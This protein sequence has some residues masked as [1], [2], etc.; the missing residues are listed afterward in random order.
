LKVVAREQIP[1]NAGPTGPHTLSRRW[2]ISAYGAV[3]AV[4]CLG[5]VQVWNP[6]DGD[7]T[8]FLYA[9]RLLG[10][11][12]ALYKDVWDV[13]QPGIFLFYLA[14][15]RLF[16][17][18]QCGVHWMELGWMAVTGG[19]ALWWARK[20]GISPRLRFLAPLFTVGAYYCAAGPWQLTQIEALTGLPLML[21]GGLALNSRKSFSLQLLIAG[22]AGGVVLVFKTALGLILLAMW[23][24]AAFLHARSS[25]GA[26]RRAVARFALFL[27]IGCALPIAVVAVWA[28]KNGFLGDLIWTTFIFPFKFFAAESREHF[29]PE[30][31]RST[32]ILFQGIIWFLLNFGLLSVLGVIGARTVIRQRRAHGIVLIAWLLAAVLTILL[33]TWWS[34]QFLLLLP[35][36]G[37]LACAGVDRLTELL[38][39]FK[40]RNLAVIAITAVVVLPL[41]F[42]L[43]A[44]L[45]V[46][47]RYWP[48]HFQKDRLEFEAERTNRD[49]FFHEVDFLMAPDALPGQIYAPDQPLTWLAS[50]RELI[51]IPFLISYSYLLPEQRKLWP[52]AIMRA[53]PAYIRLKKDTREK[54]DKIEPA[55]QQFLDVHYRRVEGHPP[56]YVR[57]D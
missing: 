31:F 50:G 8:F 25:E 55:F 9:A 33:Q 48:F 24:V 53:K 49:V 23:A 46:S 43:G 10:S 13:K 19:V 34:Y 14:A 52:C 42:M 38:G 2:K 7:Q 1:G 6:L 16:G 51:K 35:P 5:L 11:G 26:R 21:A 3:V 47:A 36:V 22:I 54:L 32:K 15:G 12:N 57:V 56:W 44:K 30:N 20:L 40:R 4:L 18:D 37:L 45:S 17:Y 41:L 29:Y 27:G 28:Q 39:G